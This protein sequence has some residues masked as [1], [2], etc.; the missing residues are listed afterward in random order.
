MNHLSQDCQY[1]S[2]SKGRTNIGG[3]D[4]SY[5]IFPFKG[6]LNLLKIIDRGIFKIIPSS[7]I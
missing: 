7:V 5:I 4:I 1:K 2:I 6:E 3:Y